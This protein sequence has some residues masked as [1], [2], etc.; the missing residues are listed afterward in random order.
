MPAQ[1]G[2]LRDWLRDSNGGNL[3]LQ[4]Q[5]ALTWADSRNAAYMGL[6]PPH[7]ENDIFIDFIS[8][9]F[10]RFWHYILGQRIGTGEL[11]DEAT[12]HTSYSTA[13]VARAGSFIALLLASTFPVLTI[14][15]LNTVQNTNIRIAMSAGFTAVF[16]LMIVVFT[17]ARRIEVF[18]ATATFAAVEVVFIGTAIGSTSG[19]GGGE[20]YLDGT[21]S[22]VNTMLKCLNATAGG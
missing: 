18:A 9:K 8:H 15:A 19:L 16:A 21:F 17:D 14:L 3:F 10:L 7:Q 12:G 5:E 20:Q 4:N 2:T 6:N 22:C 13:R 1:L 11:V